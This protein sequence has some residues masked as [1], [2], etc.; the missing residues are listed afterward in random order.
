MILNEIDID[1]VVEKFRGKYRTTHPNPLLKREGNT[2]S[3]GRERV[4]CLPDPPITAFAGFLW[5]WRS[6]QEWNFV[7][8]LLI[9]Y[10][11]EEIQI[12]VILTTTHPRLR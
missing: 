1:V 8:S 11:M 9:S 7:K 6:R 2:L 5:N 3:L 10:F 12:T 4:A